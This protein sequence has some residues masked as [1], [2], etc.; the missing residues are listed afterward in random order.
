MAGLKE[1]VD[2]E[3]ARIESKFSALA[4]SP[5]YSLIKVLASL[6][7]AD[8][9]LMQENLAKLMREIFPDTASSDALRQHWRDR[10]A[11]LEASIARGAVVFSG[12][13]GV[14]VPAGSLWQSEAGQL[15]VLA[16]AVELKN[17]SASGVVDA[18]EAGLVGN[19]KAGEKLTLASTALP[20]LDREAIVAADG[21]CGGAESEADDAYLA[22]VLA[23]ERQG[24]RNGKP[25]DLAAWAL[26]S[27]AEVSKAWEFSN[28][29]SSGSTLLVVIGGNQLSGLV[30]VGNT[31][32][33]Q[34]YLHRVAPLQLVEVRSAKIVAVD[35]EVDLLPIED[36]Q[37]S[38]EAVQNALQQYW[39]VE[40]RPLGSYSAEQLRQA[41]V[42]GQTISSAALRIVGR[43]PIVL[44]K[45]SLPTLGTVSWGAL[46]A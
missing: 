28:W 12:V 30:S 3:L 20:G 31:E 16:S 38:R 9:Y 27:G 29:D 46:N 24:V 15:Y 41:V 40:A 18:Q 4:E 2:E 8:R 35:I 13:D 5:R 21:I 45:F 34:R 42:D 10:V 19:L 26:D 36:N 7:G 22:R 1:Y 14:S 6:A 11:P 43:S 23:F 37:A 25:G 17:G 39:Q 33:V 44:D 32:L